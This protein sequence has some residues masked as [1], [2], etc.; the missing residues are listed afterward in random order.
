MRSLPEWFQPVDDN[1]VL[2]PSA[3]SCVL[4]WTWSGLANQSEPGHKLADAVRNLEQPEKHTE[5]DRDAACQFF[6]NLP[7]DVC[8]EI[9]AYL[10]EPF[11][12]E[13][14]ADSRSLW[15]RIQHGYEKRFDPAAHLRTCEELL[16]QDWHYGEPLIDD[17]LS[18]E[19]D[20][21]KLLDACNWV[22]V[23]QTEVP[24]PVQYAITECRTSGAEHPLFQT[25]VF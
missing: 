21:K 25:R 8:R 15:H 22:F 11:F 12:R 7:E 18:H 5:L 17:A 6:S 10:R 13:K 14:L 19:D 24:E 9:H 16:A 1:F 2:G 4:R 23:L 3:S 20:A